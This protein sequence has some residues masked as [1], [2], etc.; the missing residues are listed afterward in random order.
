LFFF[1]NDQILVDSVVIS[2]LGK[3]DHGS[4]PWHCDRR[5]L[6]LLDPK[7]NLQIRLNWWWKSKYNFNSKVGRP[8]LFWCVP[9]NLIRLNSSKNRAEHANLDIQTQK[10]NQSH[11]LMGWQ[12][13]PPNN[14]LFY[15]LLI[16]L[17]YNL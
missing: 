2:E 6:K 10:S 12:A 8:S 4:I 15:F 1:F 11:L 5:G 7:T 17:V 9:F 16:N 3:Y 14:F 13:S